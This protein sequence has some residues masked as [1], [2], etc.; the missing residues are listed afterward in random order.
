MKWT[1]QVPGEF[2]RD[3]I[4]AH[5]ARYLN[6][7][8]SVNAISFN[9]V[10]QFNVARLGTTRETT[11]VLGVASM[12]QVADEVLLPEAPA[13]AVDVGQALRDM[14]DRRRARAMEMPAE[15]RKSVV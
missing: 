10:D 3:A 13:P 4:E 8:V 7:G 12:P 11:L 9:G 6:T 14:A 5:L 15:D 2:V 1:L